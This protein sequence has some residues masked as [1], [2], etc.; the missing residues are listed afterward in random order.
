MID[1]TR[2]GNELRFVNHK[3]HG[4]CNT[5]MMNIGGD[6]RVA[7]YAAHDIEAGAELFFDYKYEEFQ[8]QRFLKPT[9]RKI[10][11]KHTTT[12]N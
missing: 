7:F 12:K 4:N 8:V 11:A 6:Y 2:K 9:D 5:R 10:L 3:K 1:A